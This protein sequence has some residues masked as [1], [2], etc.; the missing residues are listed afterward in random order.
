M[1]PVAAGL[2]LFDAAGKDD[3]RPLATDLRALNLNPREKLLYD[4]LDQN[5]PARWMN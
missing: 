2:N 4:M 3:K 5:T 1:Q